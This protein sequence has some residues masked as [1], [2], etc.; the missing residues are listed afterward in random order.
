MMMK[1]NLKDENGIPVKNGKISVTDKSTGEV[2]EGLVDEE[3]GEYVVVMPVKDP[4]KKEI[5]P[6]QQ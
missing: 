3:T 5:E 1:G 2:H 6:E 4:D